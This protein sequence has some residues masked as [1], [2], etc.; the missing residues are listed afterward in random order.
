MLEREKCTIDLSDSLRHFARKLEAKKCLQKG[1][2]IEVL[3]V[4]PVRIFGGVGH[5]LETP[6]N[7]WLAKG[8]SVNMAIKSKPYIIG[9][10]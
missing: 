6:V 10:E 7:P 5:V 2:C 4:V 1:L 8:Y 9:L 3:N